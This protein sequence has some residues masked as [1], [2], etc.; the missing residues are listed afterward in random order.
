MAFGTPGLNEMEARLWLDA[1]ERARFLRVGRV[2][3]LNRESVYAP[4]FW[5]NFV[6]A[7][8]SGDL[9]QDHAP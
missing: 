1:D 5:Q 7:T 4:D 2:L 8:Q 9:P 3:G 6:A